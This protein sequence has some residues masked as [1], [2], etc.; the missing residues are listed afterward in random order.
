MYVYANL[1]NGSTLEQM[2][3]LIKKMEIYLSQFKEIKQFQ[4]SV[5]SARRGNINVYF[6]K[7][8]QNS[9]FPY[10]L[11]ANIISKAL[12]LG[13]GS[14]GVYGLQDQGF[15]NDVREGAGSFQ[16]K[17]YGYNYDEL[18]EWA[19]KLKAKLLT[20]RRIKEV[21]INS[22][23]SYWKDDYQEFYFDLNRERMAQENINANILFSTIRPIYGK[24]MEIGSVVAD[25]GSEKISFPPNSLRSMTF[26]P[27]NIFRTERMT[28]SINCLNWLLWKRDK[29]R[30]RLPKRISNTGCACNTNI[31]VRGNKEIKF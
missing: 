5:Y 31:S 29:C 8:H 21:I 12:Q 19:E 4:T 11:K 27:C 25:N 6:T 24:N 18:Y 3:E 17:M 20:H 13:G 14:W 15:S 10:T 1:P 23:F 22:Y 2:N 26:G 28:N 7:E 30:N 16:V 9:G